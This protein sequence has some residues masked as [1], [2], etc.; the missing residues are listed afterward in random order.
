MAGGLGDRAAEGAFGGGSRRGDL[1]PGDQLPQH[2]RHLLL[3][4]GGAE[5]AAH[6]AAEGD[7][8]VG[9]GRRLEE[10]LGPEAS[11]SG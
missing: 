1:P 6:A 11:G 3:G 10:A 4:E 7:P 9:A 5:A 2:D 8:G